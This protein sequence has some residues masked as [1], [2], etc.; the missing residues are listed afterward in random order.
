MGSNF[1]RFT[2]VRVFVFVSGVSVCLRS[3]QGFVCGGVLG[4][5]MGVC[6]YIYRDG[7]RDFH[8]TLYLVLRFSHFFAA[9]WAQQL[10]PT[11][12]LG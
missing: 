7:I 12:L 6:V 1:I 9:C 8:T 11:Q 3:P 4:V 10:P 5:Y 2:C